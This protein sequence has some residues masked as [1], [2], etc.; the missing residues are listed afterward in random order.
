[1][2][3]TYLLDTCTWIDAFAAPQF[4]KPA[5]RKI[6]DQQSTIHVSSISLLEVARKED[7]GDLVF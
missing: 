3:A 1:M 5:V 6:I 7:K 4:L 2:D